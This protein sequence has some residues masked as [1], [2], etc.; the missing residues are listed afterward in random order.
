[1]NQLLRLK[2]VISP[3]VQKQVGTVTGKYGNGRYAVSLMGGGTVT[4]FFSGDVAVGSKVFIEGNTIISEA[5]NLPTHIV[6]I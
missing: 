1:M 5:P 4:P 2:K 3:D 6:Y